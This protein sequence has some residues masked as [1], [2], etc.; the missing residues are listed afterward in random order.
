VK[1]NWFGSNRL[2]FL[3]VVLFLSAIGVSAQDLNPI[4]WTLKTAVTTVKPN[5]TF[6]VQVVASIDDGW[7]LYSP[8]QPSGGPIPT[9]IGMPANQPFKPSGEIENPAPEVE[10]DPNFNL[11]T[12]FYSREAIFVLPAAA[13]K[14]T[15]PGKHTLSVTAFFQTCNDKTCL[16]PKTVKL[17]KD[18]EVAGVGPVATSS[19][20]ASGDQNVT[21]KK[22]TASKSV[23]AI[24]VE[25]D[26]VDFNG[27][28]RKFSEFRGKFVL[29]DF[30]AT[31]C[32]PCLADIPKLKAL[33]E[34]HKASGFEIIGM[35]SETIGAEA[36]APDPEFAK[37]TD[38]R[39]RQIVTT[40]GVTWTQA[41]SDTAVPVAIKLF[42]V[43][44]LPTKILIDREGRVVATIG[45][46]D[47]LAGIIEKLVAAADN[48]KVVAWCC[49]V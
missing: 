12:Q 15:A 7:H 25:F 29:L 13:D 34:K 5:E 21:P 42:G 3:T 33:Y 8:E 45:E 14:G 24:A 10:F 19:A 22:I 38:A 36:E 16:P 2:G 26:F 47:D 6:K 28:P 32:K 20:K 48:S 9:R 41:T 18:I 17:T 39:A 35:D 37:E 40:R 4:R 49:L 11:D 43:K 31:W 27:K 23:D 1:T 30:W 44:A 46:K